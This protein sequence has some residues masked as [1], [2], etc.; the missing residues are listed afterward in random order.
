MSNRPYGG[1]INGRNVGFAPKSPPVEV[2]L[3]AA[4][5]L[6][7]GMI[8]SLDPADIPD[9]A[10]TDG[11]NVRIRY[12]KISRRSGSSVY[13]VAKPDSNAI[14]EMLSYKKY[15]GTGTILRFTNTSVYKNPSAW[16]AL[17]GTLT[18][19]ITDRIH[20]TVAFDRVIFANN[21]ADPFQI[22][23]TGLTSFAALGNAPV[24]KFITV[25]ANRVIG[26]YLID[27]SGNSPIQIGWS[28]D[29][30]IAEWDGNVD[31]S[32]G[33]S[34]L[35]DSP[36]DN[37]DFITEIFG[38]TNVLIVCR[39]RSLWIGTKQPSATQP[40][41]FYCDV[42]GIGC[43][44]SNSAAVIPGG[45][46]F[47]DHRT[48]K[49]YSYVPGQPPVDISTNVE[50]AG[51]GGPSIFAN[52]EDPNNV[53]GTYDNT[54]N[55]YIVAIPSITTN[56]IRLWIFNFRTQAWTYDERVGLTY[57][58]N[59]E[60]TVSSITVD[61]LIGS[62]DS[63]IG[64]VDSMTNPNDSVPSLAYGYNDGTLLR[65]DPVN[66][67]DNGISYLSR[68]VSKQFTLPV[69]DQYICRV[70]LE[71]FV[72]VATVINLYYSKDGGISWTLGRVDTLPTLN[73]PF[74]IEWNEQIKCR[75]FMF[76]IESNSGNWDLIDYELHTYR[77]GP[78]RSS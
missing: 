17:T 14:Q 74:L 1:A 57:I 47:V 37:S 36:L 8:T 72:R 16:V 54:K 41:F 67:D 68:I 50:I 28:G 42:P 55:E 9:E 23:D 22:C 5:K 78:S 18:G 21:G 59:L 20:A 61:S 77:S 45:I 25:F 3:M 53:F 40:F 46:C 70:R 29:A 38:F 31:I 76:K 52:I 7:A 2:T 51:S 49:V 69:T 48:K 58:G 60:G 65:E 39:E 34:P 35:I 33:S 12:D 56:T 73:T 15:D 43:G 27:G 24:Y 64:T 66:L 11:L 44:C 19:S 75:K 13:G 10:I 4:Q 32:A 6:S 71:F 30:N 26:A 62:V 63:L